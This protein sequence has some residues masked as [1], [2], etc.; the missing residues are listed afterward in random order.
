MPEASTQV[1]AIRACTK[2]FTLVE[3]I[4]VIVILGVLS[5]IGANFVISTMNS[6]Q[7]VEQRSKLINRGRLAVE[8]MTRQIRNAVPNSVRA[9]ASGS[10]IEFLPTVAGATYIGNVPASENLAPSSATIYTAPFS[11]NIGS[12]RHAVIG[13]LSNTEIYS[14]G[15]PNARADVSTFN[16]NAATPSITLTTSHRFI[17]N[18]AQH[19]VYLADDPLR[20]CLVGGSLLQYSGYGLVT[21]SINDADPGGATDLMGEGVGTRSQ[22]FLVSIGTE[23]I[24]TI[25]SIDLTF[26]RGET[27]VDLQQEA[28]VRNVP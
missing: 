16:G 21:S 2:G 4:S 12:G 9:S 13:G 14:T 1:S 7:D 22:A 19:R 20:F 11:T 3:L 23:D 26:T 17:R 27:T 10:C 5:A 6:Y 28:L 25:V 18:S 8:Q 15:S 24:N